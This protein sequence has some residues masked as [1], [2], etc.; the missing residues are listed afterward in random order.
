[1]KHVEAVEVNNPSCQCVI[2]P[3]ARGVQK[4]WRTVACRVYN[5]PTPHSHATV[6]LCNR[7]NQHAITISVLIYDLRQL[8]LV[9]S[10]SSVT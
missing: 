2:V 3:E 9:I 10:G 1:M 5:Y 6:Q 4:T 7:Y 8:W